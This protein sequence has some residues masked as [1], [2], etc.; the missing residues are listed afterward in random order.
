M[1]WTKLQFI[2]AAF[3]EI[4]LASYNFDLNPGDLE[5][6]LRRLDAMI[7]AWNAVGIRINYPLPSS[8][9]NSD[10]SSETGVP[11]F[12]NQAIILKL[13]I[14]LA[15][16]FGKTVSQDTKVGASDA[17]RALS[18]H[19]A[20]APERQLPETM[21]FGAVWDYFCEKNDIPIGNSWIEEVLIY[22]KEV[23]RKRN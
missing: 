20:Q 18:I 22:E 3:E 19:F 14:Q 15:P 21:P 6:A 2:E 1:S 16:G 13:A 4:G 9:E 10:L 7:A 8:P 5:S 23:L 12:A 11:D 17:Y